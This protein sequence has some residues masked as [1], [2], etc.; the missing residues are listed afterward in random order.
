MTATSRGNHQRDN[1]TDGKVHE[2]PKIQ[3]GMT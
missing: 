1:R 2:R 3:S